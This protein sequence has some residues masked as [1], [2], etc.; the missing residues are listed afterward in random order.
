M[1]GRERRGCV[2]E[3]PYRLGIVKTIALKA[4]D[5]IEIIVLDLH[6][7]SSGFLGSLGFIDA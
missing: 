6:L 1:I 5:L 7:K 4:L 3:V 2:S